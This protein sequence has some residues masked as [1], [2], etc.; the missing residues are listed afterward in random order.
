LTRGS[1]RG[2]CW[3]LF[4]KTFIIDSRYHAQHNPLTTICNIFVI[5]CKQVTL[6]A[7][8][9]ND[10]EKSKT[11]MKQKNV[12]SFEYASYKLQIIFRSVTDFTVA[13][14][15]FDFP[16][17]ILVHIHCGNRYI[18]MFATYLFLLQV[19]NSVKV[20]QFISTPHPMG[21]SKVLDLSE[22]QWGRF[23]LK[24]QPPR[25]FGQLIA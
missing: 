24:P 9:W 13:V 4:P 18:R 15:C 23:S 10:R 19:I 22:E 21:W 8:H 20:S 3:R 1:S 5:I 2:P 16:C 14:W 25:I 11:T 17:V 6:R 7:M 12:S